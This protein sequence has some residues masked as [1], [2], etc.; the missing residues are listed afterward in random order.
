MEKIMIMIKKISD[1]KQDA[2]VENFFE[3]IDCGNHVFY[4]EIPLKEEEG[5]SFICSVCGKTYP[6]L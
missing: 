1:L 4:I 2:E 6:G 3:C 5:Y